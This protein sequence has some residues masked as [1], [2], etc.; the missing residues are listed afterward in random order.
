MAPKATGHGTL[1]GGTLVLE[2]GSGIGA[3]RL[4]LAG[5]GAVEYPAV[6]LRRR[7]AG[8]LVLTLPGACSADQLEQGNSGARGMLGCNTLLQSTWYDVNKDMDAQ[9]ND[10]VEFLAVDLGKGHT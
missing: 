7:K 6:A 1:L 10:P 8:V 5:T 3:T 4:A 9:V 2:T